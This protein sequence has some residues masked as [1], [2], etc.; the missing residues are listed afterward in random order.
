MEEDARQARVLAGAMFVLSSCNFTPGVPSTNLGCKLVRDLAPQADPWLSAHPQRP[1]RRIL[2][3]AGP[4]L[5]AKHLC[6]VG[7]ARCWACMTDA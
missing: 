4:L 1:W 7:S 3:A 2:Q 6:A 5:P